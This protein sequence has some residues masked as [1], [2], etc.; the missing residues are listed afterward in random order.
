MILCLFNYVSEEVLG[1]KVPKKWP[2]CKD[3]RKLKNLSHESTVVPIQTFQ[4]AKDGNK[5][6]CIEEI[7]EGK[8]KKASEHV[9]ES[10][11]E[12]QI[13]LV[14]RNKDA[15]KNPL[16]ENGK[17]QHKLP[18]TISSIHY[19]SVVSGM[20]F[21]ILSTSIITLMP[22]YNVLKEPQYTLVIKI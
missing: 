5:L 4:N 14:E 16:T 21:T 9:I 13:K 10:N 15:F 12:G 20:L 17:Q 22:N 2:N 8:Q 3:I 1:T 11:E 19:F 6:V 18:G 7:E